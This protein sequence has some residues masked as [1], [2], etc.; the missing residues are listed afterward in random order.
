MA[1]ARPLPWSYLPLAQNADVRYLRTL[2]R[3][4]SQVIARASRR[5]TV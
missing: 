2:S 1:K 5:G 3:V 4:A